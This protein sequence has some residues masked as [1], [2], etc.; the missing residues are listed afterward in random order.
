MKN[1]NI[2][3]NEFNKLETDLNIILDKDFNT[4][5]PDDILCKVDRA[6]MA[7]SLEIRAPFLEQELIEYAFNLK[8]KEK[9]HF[10]NGKIPL[11]NILNKLLPQKLISKNKKRLWNSTK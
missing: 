8:F 3:F 6:S 5:L 7:N 4:Y 9:V 10:S 2:K 11:R 1:Q